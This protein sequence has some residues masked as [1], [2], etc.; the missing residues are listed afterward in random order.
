MSFKGYGV[1]RRCSR[2]S[3]M[4]SSGPI[5]LR[6]FFARQ[7]GMA[8]D[9]G[10]SRPGHRYPALAAFLA[11]RGIGGF[12]WLRPQISTKHATKFMTQ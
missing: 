6:P 2:I 1:V 10:G 9:K 3:T 5:Q 4:N 12:G 11:F 7:I 8:A